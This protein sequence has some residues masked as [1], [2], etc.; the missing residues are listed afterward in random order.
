[1]FANDV[2]VVGGC[3]HVGLPLSVALADRGLRV[4]IYDISEIAVR[5]VNDGKMPADEPDLEDAL[6]RVIGKTLTASSDPSVVG[7]AENVIVVIG[8]PV[9]SHLS[10]DP[11]AVP[12][13]F[14]QLAPHLRPG[15]L[16]ILRST[17]YP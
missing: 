13:A 6:Q 8:T 9:N 2:S 16:V 17:V 4:Q 10:A 5:L 3:G 7:D 15:Q 1:M 14:E 11:Q 12:R